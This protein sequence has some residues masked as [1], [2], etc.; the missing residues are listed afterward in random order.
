METNRSRFPIK[1]L[2]DGRALL[3]L[4]SSARVAPGWNN[5]DFSWIVLM[6]KHRRLSS[7]LHRLG[8]ISGSRYSRLL[9]LD[10]DTV[11]WDLSK[12]VPFADQTFDGVYHC[13]ILEHIN[14]EEAQGFLYECYRVL[15]RGAILRIVVPDL[16]RMARRY[17]DVMNSLPDKGDMAEHETAVEEMF[18]QMVLR[19]PRFRR[20]QKPLLRLLENV[21]VGDTA[22]SGILH[23]WMYDRFS[24]GKMLRG[25]GFE[26]LQLHTES[27]SQIAGW[28]GFD[29]D[30]EPDGTPY[31]PG[32][33]YI[34]GRR[35]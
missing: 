29:L 16:E 21:L 27:T 1:Q 11:R 4:G 2:P 35:S 17:V 6:A 20:E 8:L 13:H 10:P 9:R 31:K 19:E 7:V 25:A 5:V 26:D 14:R 3:N 30:T 12:G 32:S 33:L 22:R 34:E 23:R 15:K 18:D 24:L 28:R